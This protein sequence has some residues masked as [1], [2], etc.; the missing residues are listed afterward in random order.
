MA[1][2]HS[3]KQEA[4]AAIRKAIEDAGGR[5][6]EDTYQMSLFA[7]HHA[8]FAYNNHNKFIVNK[9]HDTLDSVKRMLSSG[10][11]V[12]TEHYELIKF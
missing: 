3:K 8:R 6:S 2:H 9:R 7:P 10:M 5:V 12:V 11:I 4:W 1:A